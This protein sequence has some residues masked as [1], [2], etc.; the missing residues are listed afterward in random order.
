MKNAYENQQNVLFL[1][2]Y[3][4]KVSGPNVRCNF[5][6]KLQQEKDFQKL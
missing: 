5:T 6:L 1:L 3:F 2:Y 4:M